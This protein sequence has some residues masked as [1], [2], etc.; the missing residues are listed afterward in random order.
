MIIVVSNNVLIL[1]LFLW[2]DMLKHFILQI[3]IIA[4]AQVRDLEYIN[5]NSEPLHKPNFTQ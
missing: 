2:F 5:I 3:K 1:Y 4:D